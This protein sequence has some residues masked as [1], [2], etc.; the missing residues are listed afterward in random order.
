M[1]PKIKQLVLGGMATNCYLVWEQ[2]QKTCAVIDPAGEAGT[3]QRTLVSLGLTPAAVLLT[4]SHFDH[5]GAVAALVR[6]YAVPV[7][8]SRAE[9]AVA[10]DA[11]LNLSAAFGIPMTVSNAE[12]LENGAILRTAGLEFTVLH[13]PGHTAGSCCY[14]LK[15]AGVLFSGDTLFYCSHGR[16]D[17][18]T[19]SERQILDSIRDQLLT[20]PGNT[21]VYPGH[22]AATTIEDEKKWYRTNDID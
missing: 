8:M 15:E 12:L 13:T 19:G 2:D 20:L 9:A 11:E 4:H 16:T 7:Y 14:Y 6:R 3:I 22:D 1:H 21:V 18:P 17:F 5:I 10:A